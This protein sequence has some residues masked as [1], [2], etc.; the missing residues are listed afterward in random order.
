MAHQHPERA[1]SRDRG[2]S[3]DR[4]LAK[5]RAK[6]AEIHALEREHR[7]GRLDTAR[8]STADRRLRAEAI[9]LLLRLEH[10]P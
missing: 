8:W 10:L 2:D 4:L 3:T 5:Y 7:A 6:C 9:R 1:A